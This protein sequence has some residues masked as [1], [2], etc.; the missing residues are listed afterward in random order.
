MSLR[1]KGE[2]IRVMP[3]K[4][5][6][7]IGLT[8]PMG[9]GKTTVAKMA[10]HMAPWV[11]VVEADF[12]A[13][14]AFKDPSILQAM[15]DRWGPSIFSM[16]HFVDRKKLAAII[17]SDTEEKAFLESLV[18]PWVGKQV[19]GERLSALKKG[20]SWVIYD[21]PLLFEKDLE[22]DFDHI[23]TVACNLEVRR[24]R[25]KIRSGMSY[26]EIQLRDRF[27]IPLEQKILRSDYVIWTDCN[28]DDL[29]KE[30][31]SWLG[32]LAHYW[33]EPDKSLA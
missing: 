18:H 17:F 5:G 1:P 11:Y 27:H 29:E 10:S 31:R 8:G 2:N 19:Q 28:L 3:K 24:H 25:L 26:E 21:V 16:S 14:Q 15:Q 9:C 32:W 33:G 4:T 22:N 12:W 20:F 30:V 6:R 23:L 7:W 13:H